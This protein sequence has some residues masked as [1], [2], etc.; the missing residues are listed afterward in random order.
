MERLQLPNND[1]NQ[2]F[3]RSETLDE[4]SL[5]L[6]LKSRKKNIYPS[7]PLLPFAY[8]PFNSVK[9]VI[10]GQD[11]YCK[12]GQ[13]NGLAFSVNKKEKIPSSLKNIYKELVRDLD[14]PMPAHG[15]LSDWAK[16]GVLLLN[17]VLT[18]EEGK[19]LSHSGLGW[20]EFTR[21]IIRLLSFEIKP[22]FLLWGNKAY[23]TFVGAVGKDRIKECTFMRAS[24]PSGNSEFAWAPVPF[25]GCGH[26]S[27]TNNILRSSGMT[28]IDWTIYS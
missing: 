9:V 13:A 21:E 8:T 6:S 22:I 2:I 5:A 18:V 14:I 4:V 10:L 16:Q 17:T 26:F 15:D 7:N 28:P 11:P 25:K 20:E 12:P 24:H 1:W 23:E 3:L 19:P 27:K